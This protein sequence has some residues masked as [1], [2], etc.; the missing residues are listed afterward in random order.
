MERKRL[1]GLLF[2]GYMGVQFMTIVMMFFF[3]WLGTKMEIPIGA[4]NY[5]F[6][7]SCFN[8]LVYF[9]IRKVINYITEDDN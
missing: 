7:Q 9:G 8:L 3:G 4:S 5:W 1:Q 2:A 6:A